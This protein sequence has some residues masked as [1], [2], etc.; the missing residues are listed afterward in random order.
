MKPWAGKSEIPPP[1]IRRISGKFRISGGYP[2]FSGFLIFRPW[3]T[4]CLTRYL[5]ELES[6]ILFLIYNSKKGLLFFLKVIISVIIFSLIIFNIISTVMV[7][8]T[9]LKKEPSRFRRQVSTTT[10]FI[11]GFRFTVKQS[12]FACSGCNHWKMGKHGGPG[13]SWTSSLFK[14]SCKRPISR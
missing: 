3:I 12:I 7:T 8:L 13:F 10:L 2:E 9:S 14:K 4:N 5:Q 6:N 11:N 1:D